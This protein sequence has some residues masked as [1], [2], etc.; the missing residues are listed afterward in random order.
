MDTLVQRAMKKDAESFIR[1]M[2]ENKQSMLKVAYGFFS[3]E[4]DVPMLPEGTNDDYVAT[5][6]DA[7]GRPLE[8]RNFGHYLSMSHYGRDVSE[9][10][11]YLLKTQDFL[12][13]KGNN[14]YMQ[15]EK[16]IFRTTVRFDE[17]ASVSDKT[18][19]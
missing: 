1:L 17:E 2:E 15:P 5:I 10:T 9:M 4:E 11:V 12:D 18:K 19:E 7:D 16:A 3:N 13:Y 6:W 14:A 8:N